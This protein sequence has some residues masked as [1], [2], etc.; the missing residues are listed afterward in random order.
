MRLAVLGLLK[1]ATAGLLVAALLDLRL[2]G[3]LRPRTRIYLVDLSAS[4][5][6]PGSPES[7]TPA[8][9][10]RLAAA[11]APRHDRVAVLAI[12]GAPRLLYEGPPGGFPALPPDSP[13]DEETDLAAPLIAALLRIPSD[14]DADILLFS[15]GRPTRGDL[16]SALAAC[17]ARGVPVHTVSLGPIRPA[18]ARIVRVEAPAFVASRE[19]WA[20]DVEVESG[21]DGT[22][23]VELEAPFGRA[24]RE[25]TLVRD[26]PR[27]VR[28]SAP[29]IAERTDVRVSIRAR[30][31]EDACP[32]NDSA[33]RTIQT[34]T[35]QRRV[36][37]LA[38]E[39]SAAATILRAQPGLLV[40]ESAAFR[41][42]FE[43]D[44]VVLDNFPL[45]EARPEDLRRLR[46]FVAVFGGGLAVFG[47]PDA[48]G[49]GGYAN[50]PVEEVLPVWAFPDETL[51]LAVVL[52][53]SGSMNAELPNL[54]R[55]KMDAARQAIARLLEELRPKDL[56]TVITAPDA[57]ALA[58]LSTDRGPLLSAL[59]SLGAGGETAIAKPVLEAVRRLDAATAPRKHVLLLTD[60]VTKGETFEALR[61]ELESASIGLTFVLTGDQPS[62]EIVRL[63]APVPVGNWEAL[64]AQLAKLLRESREPFFAPRLPMKPVGRHRETDGIDTW[65]RPG[66]INRVSTKPAVRLAVVCE[67]HPVLAFRTAGRGASAAATLGLAWSGGLDRWADLS[68]LV[69]QSVLG[70][71]PGDVGGYRL[72]CAGAGSELLLSATGP[73][74][75]PMELVVESDTGAD[76]RLKRVGRT[77][78]EGRVA[79]PVT[80]TAVFRVRGVRGGNVV[81]HAPYP[82]EFRRLGPDD[83][84]LER[85]ATTTGGRAVRRP[86]DLQAGPPMRP[87]QRS[88]RATFLI[89][90]LVA[91]LLDLGISTFWVSRR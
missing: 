64:S 85:I 71:V 81:F 5:G 72:S 30:S 69:V 13:P 19:P 75:G 50:T 90:A 86:E 53:C 43:F 26:V 17:A 56:A 77:S 44:G 80:G 79:A 62:P 12:G 9:A 18:D 61:A 15:D 88:G 1:L 65:P 48:Y 47:G 31:F 38:T 78:W 63:S 20:I 51:A 16:E 40:T 68:R 8:D 7:L 29:A 24:V 70:T 84:A 52:D 39:R 89:A 59:A 76:V 21:V 25:V 57:T 74:D 14:R 2:P 42:P 41:D 67:D 58:P 46:D 27:V 66:R 49:P 4:A 22:A 35:D 32:R 82:P 83:D 45:R 60:G 33:R 54:R 55:S 34:R 73:E 37:V 36:L 28:F 87:T 6:V 91:F 11:D 10:W 3:G 23:D